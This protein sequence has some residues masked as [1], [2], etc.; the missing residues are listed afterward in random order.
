MDSLADSKLSLQRI[1]GTTAGVLAC[2]LLRT[3]NAGE[4]NSPSYL[5][6]RMYV[7]ANNDMSVNMENKS[8]VPRNKITK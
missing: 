5:T 7:T 6:V 8:I 1:R 3:D 2:H 4:H